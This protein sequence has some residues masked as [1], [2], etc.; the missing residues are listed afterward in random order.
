M[1]LM[2]YEHDGSHFTVN[3][4]YPKEGPAD[5]FE[6]DNLEVLK[7]GKKIDNFGAVW[8]GAE[9]HI[10]AYYGSMVAAYLNDNT[11][12]DFTYVCKDLKEFKKYNQSY[13]HE[14]KGR[15][16]PDV[17][18]TDFGEKGYLSVI[19]KSKSTGEHFAYYFGEE[20][21]VAVIAF[22]NG[23]TASNIEELVLNSLVEDVEK[24]KILFM[25]SQTKDWLKDEYP[26]L[27]EKK[28]AR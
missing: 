15:E 10:S 3:G 28:N 13:S 5:I 21:Q 16:I 2:E 8:S 17:F 23:S 1:L 27:F 20:N 9:V 6:A 7:G 25:T 24:N 19:S 12:V 11:T 4:K 22:D 26:E 18:Y 14:I